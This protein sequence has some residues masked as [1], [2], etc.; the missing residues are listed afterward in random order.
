MQAPR[1]VPDG[2]MKD[3]QRLSF[4][5][6]IVHTRCATERVEGAADGGDDTFGVIMSAKTGPS[7]RRTFYLLEILPRIQQ[8]YDC[9]TV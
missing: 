7:R 6:W 3:T 9:A 8:R 5:G 4:S 1:G 2:H